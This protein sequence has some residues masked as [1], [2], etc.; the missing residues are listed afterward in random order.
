MSEFKVALDYLEACQ[1]WQEVISAQPTVETKDAAGDEARKSLMW[2]SFHDTRNIIIGGEAALY[3]PDGTADLEEKVWPY[4]QFGEL[5][6]AGWLG[7]TYYMRLRE[8]ATLIW[9]V[10]EP[11]VLGPSEEINGAPTDDE[12]NKDEP[13]YRLLINEPLKRTLHFPVGLINYALCYGR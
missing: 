7:R 2:H 13:S 11:R 4:V 10:Y 1:A 3:I 9:P 5:V 12:T 8:E 6:T